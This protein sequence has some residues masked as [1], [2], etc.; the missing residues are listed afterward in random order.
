MDKKRILKISAVA[1]IS[2][3][4]GF[5]GGME[6]K[7]YQIRKALSDVFDEPSQQ[8]IPTPEKS[9]QE[10]QD[11]YV[12]IEKN[13]GDTIEF[14]IIKF[15]ANGVKE[16][17]TLTGGSFR[18]AIAKENA[19]FV[20]IDLSITNIT[21]A[22]FTFFPDDGFRLVDNK[23]RQFTTYGDTIGSIE[24]YLNVRELAPS[25][26]ENGVLVYEIPKDATGYSL[27]IGKAGTNEIYKVI[28]K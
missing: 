1:I 21:D 3:G 7:A 15:K 22:N 6:Y 20:I 8:V 18:P 9:E 23:E 12:F 5:L 19:K 14:A 4:L 27:V 17:Q 11:D 26:T 13:I 25:I 28:L 10:K 2:F 24:N 16:T